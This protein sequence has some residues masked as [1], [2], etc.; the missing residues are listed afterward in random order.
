M[1]KDLTKLT[2]E[3]IFSIMAAKLGNS[4][5]ELIN[6]DLNRP[7]TKGGGLL[8]DN[9]ILTTTVNIFLNKES[10]Q[11]VAKNFTFFAKFFPTSEMQSMFCRETGAFKKEV[12]MYGMFETIRAANI[13]YIDCVPRCYFSKADYVLVLEDLIGEGYKV[14]DKRNL[15]DY[16]AV[17]VVLRSLA[18]LH[19]TSIIYEEMVSRDSGKIYRLSED[20]PD[21][22]EDTFYNDRENFINLRGVQASIKALCSE[23]DIFGIPAILESG[24]DF[25]EVLREQCNRVYTL[26]KRS[27]RFR[28]VISH[29]DLWSTNFLIKFNKDQEPEDCKLVDF[30]C[31]RYVPPSHDVMALLYLTTNREFRREHLY[32]AIG[33]YYTNLEKYLKLSG[34]NINQILTIQDFLTSCEEQKLFAI[35]QTA[36]Y[37]QL[38]LIDDEKLEKLFGDIEGNEESVFE[39]RTALILDNIEGDAVYRERLRESMLDLK[40]YC[41]RL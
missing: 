25:K 40:D 16:D 27:G 33:L 9:A 28:N 20:H 10:Q 5:F 35:F 2:T 19:A 1:T 29:G 7:D 14:L 30:Q 12:F 11:K 36:T 34:V 37:L 39:D 24:R 17:L 3:E 22:F 18:K 41:D 38:I 8:C 15:L 23:V 6:Y 26:V 31:G 13:H 21:D 32:E 4:N